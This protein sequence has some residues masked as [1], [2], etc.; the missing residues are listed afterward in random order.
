M[1]VCVCVCM[2]MCLAC[3]ENVCLLPFAGMRHEPQPIM[4][5]NM[6]QGHSLPTWPARAA[7]QLLDSTPYALKPTISHN[8][9]DGAKQLPSFGAFW[10]QGIH[11]IKHA[12]WRALERGAQFVL[13]GS[14]PDP[15]V[16][17]WPPCLPSSSYKMLLSHCRGLNLCSLDQPQTP[18]CRH[19]PPASPPLFQA[20]V[21]S[22]CCGAPKRSDQQQAQLASCSLLE[23]S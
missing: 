11:L 22:R 17:A 2:C 5:L 13:L 12:A 9:F 21:M 1:C 4:L 10:L 15:K 19:G 7:V 20:M 16:Q 23:P 14:A 3:A 18:K 8:F 6:T